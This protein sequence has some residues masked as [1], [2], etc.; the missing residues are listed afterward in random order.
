M[1]L[2]DAEYATWLNSA[3]AEFESIDNLLVKNL[4]GQPELA[5]SDQDEIKSYLEDI[6]ESDVQDISLVRFNGGS[7]SES[8]DAKDERMAGSIER[9]TTDNAY[10]PI[11]VKRPLGA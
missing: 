3:A 9:T 2:N 5:T 10:V 4:Q 8:W 7:G 1:A 6:S 11:L